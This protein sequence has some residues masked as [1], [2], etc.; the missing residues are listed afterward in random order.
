VYNYLLEHPAGS[1]KSQRQFI[2]NE[3]KKLQSNYK[4][5]LDFVK[6]YRE[7]DTTLDKYYFV[8]GRDNL[9][10]VSDTSHF[11]TDAEFSTSHDN[12]MAKIIAYDLLVN[13]Y[14]QQLNALGLATAINPE[15][16]QT[17]D[18]LNLKWT[19]NK[20]DLIELIYALQ[21]SGAIK[22]GQAGIKEMVTACEQM[23]NIE[24]GQ[25]YK[26]YVE[27]RTRKKDRTS[28][29][30]LLKQKLEYKMNNDDG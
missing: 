2:D 3:I 6:Y 22:D 12:A 7:N 30:T 29:I 19:A 27:L 11:Y 10:L 15:T 8:R 4:R 28:F 9:S 20:T 21:A 5:N 14:N 25:Y 13:F 24:L 23:F 16:R 26:T 17:C 18:Q 1:I